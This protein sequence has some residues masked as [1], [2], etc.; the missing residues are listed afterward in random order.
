[1]KGGGIYNNDVTNLKILNSAFNRNLVNFDKI[2]KINQ[3]G[4]FYSLTQGGS[5]FFKYS[6]KN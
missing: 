6:E 5:I 1:M 3:K 4:E 2:Q